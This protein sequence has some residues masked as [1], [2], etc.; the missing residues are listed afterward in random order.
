MNLK[1]STDLN[2]ISLNQQTNFRLNETNK[3]KNYFDLYKLL[4][5]Q[6]LN[7]FFDSI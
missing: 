6:D 1:S 3:I 2:A 7:C 4:Y 5:R